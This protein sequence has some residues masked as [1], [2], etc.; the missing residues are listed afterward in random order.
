MGKISKA[1]DKYSAEFHQKR[2][3]VN[4]ISGTFARSREPAPRF[5]KPDLEWYED[6]KTK[7]IAQHPGESIKTIMF[8]GTHH[9]GGVTT[10][11]INFAKTLVFDEKLKVL[12]MDVNMRTPRFRDFFNINHDQGL[13]ELI[14][15]GDT[16][17]F[18]VI[19]V[20]KSH[21]FVLAT[22]GNNVGPVGLFESKRFE[23]FL[24]KARDSFD[25]IILDAAPIPS[26][27]ESRVLCKK[28]DGVVLVVESGKIR[29]QVAL[30]AK[31]EL[32]DAGA[33]ILG[34]VI[35]RRKHHIPEWI[36]KRL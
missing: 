15:D 31:K 33:R 17:A 21:L 35:N 1:L 26:F 16:K 7:I 19:R 25:Q 12:L 11:A 5:I 22:G 13:T 8:T 30:R 10:T 32:E 3:E 14:T 23:Q 4:T 18:K 6:I 28:V 27:A 29:R 34:V 2:A 36:Y 20:G 24:A 9:G